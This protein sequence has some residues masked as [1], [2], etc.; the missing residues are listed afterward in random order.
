MKI[1]FSNF[2]NNWRCLLRSWKPRGHI[3]LPSNAEATLAKTSNPE[4]PVGKGVGCL[5]QVRTR[6]RGWR[7]CR[8]RPWKPTRMPCASSVRRSTWNRFFCSSKEARPRRGCRPRSCNRRQ[9]RWLVR[10][11]WNSEDAMSCLAIWNRLIIWTNSHK[12]KTFNF[13]SFVEVFF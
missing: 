6:Q 4:S 5:L 1:Y 3:L 13:L 2:D 9:R 11:R 7:S 8:T 12:W 10:W